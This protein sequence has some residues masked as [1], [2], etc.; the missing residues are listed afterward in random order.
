MKKSYKYDCKTKSVSLSGTVKYG[1][2]I[3][4][5]WHTGNDN[6]SLKNKIEFQNNNPP[7]DSVKE[8][9]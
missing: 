4:I 5:Q 6:F 8:I 9:K 7:G 1:R 3:W 2:E